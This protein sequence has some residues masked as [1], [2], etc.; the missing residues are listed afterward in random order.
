MSDEPKEPGDP[1]AESPQPDKATG[2]NL[3]EVSEDELKGILAAHARWLESGE[4]EG[5]KADLSKTNLRVANLR[6][7]NLRRADLTEAKLNRATLEDANLS[8]ATL[9]GAVLR[10]AHLYRTNFQN[11]DIKGAEFQ[12]ADLKEAN[13]RDAN[14]QNANFEDAKSFLSEQLAGTNVSG[15]TL[16]GDIAEF[17][18]LDHVTEI[19]KHA[20]NIFLAVI[21]GCVFSWLTIA[22]TTDV[23]LLTNTASTP[24]PIIQTK[25][26]IAGFYFA[27][28]LILLSLYIY[29]HM[30]LQRLW[31]SLAGLPAIFPDGRSLDERAYP[32]LL[33][34]LVGANVPR[35]KEDRPTFSRQQV[36]LSILTAWCL[37]PLT[38]GWFWLRYL[39]VHDWIGTGVHI[40]LV[41]LAVTHGVGYF[42]RAQATLR[43]RQR[44][45]FTWKIWR[46]RS[47]VPYAHAALFVGL[48]A[49]AIIVSDGAINGDPPDRAKLSFHRLA[50]PFGAIEIPLVHRK[51]VPVAFDLVGYRTALNIGQEDVS[52]KPANWT[53][54][55]KK[56]D[57][58]T[59]GDLAVVKPAQLAGRDLRFAKA[60]WAFLPKARLIGANLQG[61]NLEGANL[62]MGI[63]VDA[64]LQGANLTG[65]NLQGAALTGANLQEA[66]LARANLHGANLCGAQGLTKEQLEGKVWKGANWNEKTKFPDY[67]K[68]YQVKPCPEEP[69]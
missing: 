42:W 56:P 52:I 32:W 44:S 43:G 6:D 23:A 69:K 41:A 11:A 18:G 39:P 25:V 66:N 37:V 20:R 40:A 30:Y 8:N 3:R 29:L 14:L 59:P 9:D 53:G 33:T 4:K 26:P 10:G 60:D 38:I 62:Q 19:S 17:K 28:P 68:D 55:R 57:K 15:A 64:N 5:E 22:T 35:L 2:P 1:A 46:W 54:L 7:A 65:A 36:F 16:P 67:L 51:F 24:L 12:G 34:S 58:W 61:A 13:L 31:S 50:T 45:K 27:A 48:A 63:L 47:L 49:A 21:G